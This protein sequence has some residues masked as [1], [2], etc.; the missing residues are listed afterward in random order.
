MMLKSLTI[1]T[2]NTKVVKLL[3]IEVF[4]DLNFFFN[5]NKFLYSFYILLS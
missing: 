3:S 4:I 1:N 5:N 2:E